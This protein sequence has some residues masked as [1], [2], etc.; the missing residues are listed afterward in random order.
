MKESIEVTFSIAINLAFRRWS[1]FT[2][3]STRGEFWF[4]TLFQMI[5]ALPLFILDAIL[6]SFPP[7]YPLTT[8]FWIIMLAPTLS[9]S[10]RRLHDQNK[11]WW[12]LLI[13]LIPI[14]GW[15]A[16]IKIYANPTTAY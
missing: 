8:I 5:C 15:A 9:I 6:L 14:I 2:G 16:I 10:V 11:K 3:R 12:W 7:F 13:W 1:D 4:F